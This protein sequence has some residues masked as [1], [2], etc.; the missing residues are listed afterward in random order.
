MY[1]IFGGKSQGKLDYAKQIYGKKRTVCDLESCA[2]ED[3]L[4]ADILINIQAAVK[5]MLISGQNPSGYFKNHID[6]FS[7]KILIGDE[8]GCG[9]VPVDA[10]E[11][12]WRDETGWVYQFLVSKAER[13][14][15]VWAGIGQILKQSM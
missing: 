12:E 8:I 7:G 5:S 15:R 3:A 14:D 2:I 13:V 1:F 10:L 9:I 4:S 11:R 6:Q